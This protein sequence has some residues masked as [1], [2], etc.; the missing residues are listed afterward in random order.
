[1]H[2]TYINQVNWFFIRLRHCV[3]RLLFQ[4]INRSNPRHDTI[5]DIHEHGRGEQKGTNRQ[6]GHDAHQ[7]QDD[8]VEGTVLIGT[9]KVVPTKETQG[10]GGRRPRVGEK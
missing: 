8:G 4:A 6:E 7:V 10:K 1:M 5:T 3:G 9:E 2:Q